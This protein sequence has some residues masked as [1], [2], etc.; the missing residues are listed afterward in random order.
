MVEVTKMSELC[1]IEDEM[2]VGSKK[3]LRLE[4]A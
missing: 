4:Y 2:L 1:R 3:V